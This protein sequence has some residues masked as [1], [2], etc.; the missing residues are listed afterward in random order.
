MNYGAQEAASP[1]RNC[2]CVGHIW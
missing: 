1:S 2:S